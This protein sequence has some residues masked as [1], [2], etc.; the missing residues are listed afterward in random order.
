MV[1]SRM[2]VPGIEMGGQHPTLFKLSKCLSILE[3]I[4]KPLAHTIK[5]LALTSTRESLRLCMP[6]LGLATISEYQAL[7]I[8][9]D[10]SD[11]ISQKPVKK[12]KMQCT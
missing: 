11:L 3:C 9:W 7:Y 12:L 8:K 1:S 4:L 5:E 10:P 6:L 2:M